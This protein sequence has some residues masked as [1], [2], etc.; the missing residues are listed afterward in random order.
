M[1]EKNIYKKKLNKLMTEKEAVSRFLKD[2]DCFTVG[3]FLLN[4]ESDSVFREIAR[5][6]QKHLKYIE[7]SCTLT[8]DILIGLGAIDRFDQAYIP[9]RQIGGVAGLPCL[10]RCLSIGDPKPVNLSGILKTEGYQGDEDPLQI[11][12]WTNYMVSLQFIAGSMN[13]PFIPCRTALGSDVI[14][15]N[16]EIKMMKDPYE[17]TEVAL[18][19]ACNPDVAFINVQ[20]A[21]RRGNGQIFG[22]KGVDEWKARAAKHVVLFTEELVSTEE[23][24]KHPTTTVVPSHCTDAVVHLPFYS[25]PNG[26]FGSY[27]IDPLFILESTLARQTPDGHKAWMDKWVFGCEDHFDYCDKFGWEKLEALA[28]SEKKLNQIPN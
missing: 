12:D 17:D 4:R 9:Q 6:G 15:N 26:G 8:I 28:K 11:V 21:D 23:I 22:Q 25:H 5:Q 20:K 2:G 16:K 14:K 18:I 10:D 13:I 7:E 27:S 24:M 3:G 19:P 1:S